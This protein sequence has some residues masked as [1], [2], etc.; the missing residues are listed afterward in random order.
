[1][2]VGIGILYLALLGSVVLW[3]HC[4]TRN[5]GGVE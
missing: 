4:A 1:M 2:W 5:N 3:V